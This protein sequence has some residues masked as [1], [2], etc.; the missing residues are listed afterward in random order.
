MVRLALRNPYTVIV[1]GLAILI[2]GVTALDRIPADLLPIFKTPAVQILTF[3]PGMPAEIVERDITTRLERWTGQSN[4]VARQESKSMIGVSIVKDYFRPDIDP[5]T[6]MS[7]VTS[8]AM[9]DLYYLP[10]GTV[11][12]MVMPFDPTATV[13]LALITVS[14]PSF[15]ETK[16]YDVAYFDLRNRLQG[17]TGVIAPAVYGGKLR[18]ILAYVDREKLQARGLSPMDVVKA[19]RSSN[20]M[21]P[22]GNAKFGS[23]DYQINANSMVPEVDQINDFPIKI[24]GGAPVYVKDVAH[25]EDSNQIQT[26]VVRVNG[27]RQVYIPIYRQPGANTIQI[28]DGVKEAITTILQRLPKGI[29]LDVVMDQSVY[30]RKAI[31]DLIQEGVLGAALAAVMV[32]LFLG[33]VHSMGI[34][35]LSLPL[36]I[37]AACTGLFFTGQSL[38]AMT[39]GGL[40]LAV[41]LLIDQTIVVLENISRH[42]EMGKSPLTAALDGAGEVATPVL[43]ITLTIVAVFFPIVFLT[44]IGKF[45]FTPLALSVTLALAASY[46]LAMTLVPACASRF[47]KAKASD[48]LRAESREPGGKGA[49]EP[50][51]RGAEISPAPPL[52]RSGRWF[53]P[54]REQYGRFLQ[55]VLARKKR[56]LVTAAVI[57]LS[58]LAI[59]PLIGTELFPP[60]DAGQLMIRVRAPS[61]T[62]VEVTEELIKDVEQVIHQTVPPEEL[63]MMISNIGVL[64]DWPAAYTPNSGPMDAFVNL[65]FSEDRRRT[66]QAYARALRRRL[67]ERFPGIEF[68]FDT[69]GLITAALNFG[70]PSP[71]N[72]QVEGNR[73]DVADA[74]ARQIKGLVEQVPGSVDVRIQQKIDYPQI[75]VHVDRV[76]A[77]HL[78]LTQEN[79]VKNIVTT[80][81]SSINFDPAFW[82]DHRNGNHYFIGAQYREG[83]IASIETLRD[84]PI[85]SPLQPAPVSLRTIATFSRNTAPAEINHLNITR[86]IDVFASVEGRDI[87]QVAADIEAKLETLKTPEGYV[88]RM[89]GEVQSMRESFGNLGFGLILAVMLVYLVMVIQ[90]RSFLDPLIVMFAVPLGIVGVLWMLFLTGTNFNI[91]SLMGMIMMVGIVVA[92][93]LLMVDFANRRRGE[94]VEVEPAILEAAKIRLR[95]ILM[96]S[97]AATLGLVP[98]AIGGGANIPLARAVIGGVLASTALTLV[99]VPI[100]YTV[101]KTST[102]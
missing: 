74:L 28:V 53:D 75:E 73:L 5:N 77:A 23:F 86:V 45:L 43:L 37:L 95:P 8:L 89:R 67:H 42:L 68:A 49:E 57:F 11:P 47:L 30:V 2:F 12:P 41:G 13:P 96:T 62:R 99:V 92:F 35:L 10:P 60:V 25:T 79:V 83:D 39:L 34:V 85:T 31:A 33:S 3:Y 46:I 70:L 44:G 80:L 9:S 100:L 51:G 40:A 15:D 102:D 58:S 88:V 26:N 19:I 16:L 36:A 52:L 55:W 59:Y 24:D 90:F 29:N 66:A 65:Q 6:A 21:I 101:F 54:V 84:I 87:G 22:T 69:G 82:I 93:S 71:I 18:R 7:Q 72:I 20:L 4:G 14:S 56:A 63:K 97:L 48:E 38:N 61:G 32:L 94:G 81:N 78:G 1:M 98:M 64:Y 76:K 27:R 50:G 17:I 91:Q